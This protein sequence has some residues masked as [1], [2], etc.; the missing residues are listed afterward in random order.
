MTFLLVYEG[1]FHWPKPT[2][3]GSLC[4]AEQGAQKGRLRVIKTRN[5]RGWVVGVAATVIFCG[6]GWGHPQGRFLANRPK[7]GNPFRLTLNDPSF[8]SMGEISPF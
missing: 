7:R 8:R 6:F 4:K 2:Q 5:R 1:G 3:I